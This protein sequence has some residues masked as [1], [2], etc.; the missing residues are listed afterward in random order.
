MRLS[1]VFAGLLIGAALAAGCGSA[2]D[3]EASPAMSSNAGG[4]TAATTA[5]DTFAGGRTT[6][7]GGAPADETALLERIDLG[8]HDGYDRVVF[9]FRGAHLPGYRVGFVK[10]PL[11]E[12]G[13]G[14]DVPIEGGAI[15]GVRLEPA[16]G[17][18]LNQ[19]EGKLVYTGPKRVGGKEAGLQTITELART[20]DFEGVLQWAIGL[21]DASDFRVLELADPARLVVDVAA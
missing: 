20:G 6:V 11:S 8:R 16:S 18:D 1:G 5:P 9:R 10:R 21:D 3:P 12:D 15:L 17:F 2:D 4:T 19:G 13:S 7:T 14:A